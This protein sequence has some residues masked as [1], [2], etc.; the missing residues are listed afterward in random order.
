MPQ[1]TATLTAHLSEDGKEGPQ[2]GVITIEI[3]YDPPLKAGEYS[4]LENVL[5]GMIENGPGLAIP[6][7]TA[8]RE[9]VIPFK[10]R[11]DM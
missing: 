4:V 3:S 8:S 6:V 9:P 10:P 5:R 1:R 11:G 2:I 7:G